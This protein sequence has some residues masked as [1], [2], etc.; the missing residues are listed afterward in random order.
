MDQTNGA[1]K[2]V[3][4]VVIDRNNTRGME[5]MATVAR[6]IVQQNGCSWTIDLN[7]ILLFSDLIKHVLYTLSTNRD[8]FPRH[9]LRNVSMNWVLIESDVAVSAHVFVMAN[10]RKSKLS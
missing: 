2:E 8:S 3:D 5:V 9:S 10:Q 7:S 4:Q 1:F 6:R